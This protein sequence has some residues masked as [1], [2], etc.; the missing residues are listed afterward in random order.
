MTCNI[1]KPSEINMIT[2]PHGDLLTTG[3]LA[4]YDSWDDWEQDVPVHGLWYCSVSP[5]EDPIKS[6][7]QFAES[8][9]PEWSS[10]VWLTESQEKMGSQGASQRT[11]PSVLGGP[12]SVWNPHQGGPSWELTWLDPLVSDGYSLLLNIFP[13]E[14]SRVFPIKMVDLSSSWCK[15]LPEG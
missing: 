12:G 10:L 6:H 9:P 13:V 2:P 14:S 1:L 4:I 3:V 8:Q 11:K 5:S 15:C 7:E